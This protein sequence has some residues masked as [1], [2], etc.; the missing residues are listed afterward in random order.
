MPH[1]AGEPRNQLIMLS[2]ESSVPQD[3]FVRVIDAFVDA[4]D[5]ESFGFDHTTSKDEGRP[6]FHPSILLKLYLYGYRYGIR[7]SR[8]L[9][10]EARLNLEALW[11]TS[12]QNPRYKTIADFRKKHAKAFRQ[13][14]RSFVVLLKDWN[15]VDGKTIA[16]D[17]F[18]I[19]AQNSLKNNLNQAKIE[20]HLAYIDDKIDQYETELDRADSEDQRQELRE[21]LR[22]QQARKSSYQAAEKKLQETGQDQISLT[23]PDARAVVLH[24][25]IVNVGYNVQASVDSKN[26]LLVEFD[27]GDVNDSHALAPMAEA[28]RE[29]LKTEQMDVLAD[30]G[31]HT[32]EELQKCEQ[33]GITTYISP[34]APVVKDSKLFPVT[35]FIYSEQDD[36]YTCPAGEIM[37]TNKVW[38]AHSGRNKSV[39]YRF[40]RYTTTVCKT[41]AFRSQCTN[42]KQNGRVIER[43]EY[44][45]SI[46]RNNIRVTANPNYYRQRQQL[47][48]H[49][50]GTLKRQR[51]FTFT[52]MKQKHNVLGEVGLEF[53]GYNLVRCTTVMGITELIKALKKGCFSTFKRFFKLFFGSNPG[54]GFPKAKDLI[55]YCS[56]ITHL[57]TQG[58][59]I[60]LYI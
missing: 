44:A 7:S 39:P 26:K 60:M 35:D 5:L 1:L 33:Q 37:K 27:T 19:R 40:Q 56:K 20:R 36:T 57:H 58:T 15:L 43:S 11:L 49:P 3:A 55:F 41:C 2:L 31:Y 12:C 54:P 30:K 38:H 52:L 48:E 28:T 29:L 6:C 8:K 9:E 21:K 13:V 51:G 42:N 46:E 22:S 14:F 10:R 24:R 59:I 47:A 25:N 17:S 4:T 45:G 23:D 34:K 53:I 32:G 50:F 16:I 18:K